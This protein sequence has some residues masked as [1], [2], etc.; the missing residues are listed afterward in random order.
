MALMALSSVPAMA[1]SDDD[2]EIDN[3]LQYVLADG[4]VLSDGAE[5]TA[6][7][8]EDNGFDYQIPSGV[9]VNNTTEDQVFTSMEVTIT[10]LDN[11]TI[12]CCF[13]QT[14]Q[15]SAQ[16]GT[17]T[18]IGGSIDGNESKHTLQTEWIPE[19]STSYGEAK[20]TFRIR[21]HAPKISAL[22]IA[23]AGEVTG[24]GPSITITFVNADPTGI[25]AVSN[26][27]VNQ[28]VAIY[29]LRGEEL[30]GMQK[31]VNIVRYADGTAKK[32]IK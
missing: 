27:T 23:S 6:N 15:T 31:G 1:Q 9:Y 10:K 26:M 20:A 22:G 8:A 17:F 24:Y 29:N 7:T 19:S 16:V 18:T 28:P 5:I 13:P 12:S 3:T 2:D 25:N 11:G 4:T 32:V 30:S 14:C 21:M